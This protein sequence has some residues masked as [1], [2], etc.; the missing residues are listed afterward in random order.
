MASALSS[1]LFLGASAA[2]I[3]G[4]AVLK[5]EYLPYA[6]AVAATIGLIQ[7]LVG[8]GAGARKS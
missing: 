1:P 8:G 2:I 3:I 6:V 4:T 5:A 7:S